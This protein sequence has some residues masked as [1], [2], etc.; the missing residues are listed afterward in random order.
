M[1]LKVRTIRDIG[2]LIR[3]ARRKAGLTQADLAKKVGAGARWIHEL[4]HGRPTVEAGRMLLVMNILGITLYVS[5]PA[6]EAHMSTE[7]HD[8]DYIVSRAT[9][10]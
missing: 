6:H 2:L 4:E 3:D 8:I 7:E 5:P 1:P 10:P 9:H